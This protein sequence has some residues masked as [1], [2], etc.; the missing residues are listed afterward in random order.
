VFVTLKIDIYF[1]LVYSEIW[2]RFSRTCSC[3]EGIVSAVKVS[4]W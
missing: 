4:N 1:R 2:S 3:A